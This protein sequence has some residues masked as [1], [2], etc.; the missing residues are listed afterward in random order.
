MMVGGFVGR[1]N[2]GLLHLVRIYPSPY[3]ISQSVHAVTGFASKAFTAPF[4]K[5]LSLVRLY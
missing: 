3:N 2:A 4:Q 5:S 1:V